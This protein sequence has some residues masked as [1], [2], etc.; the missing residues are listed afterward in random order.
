L[1]SAAALG[2]HFLHLRMLSR[3]AKLYLVATVFQGFGAGIWQV[4]FYLYLNLHEVGFQFDFIGNMFT[5]G[6]VATGLI[7][8]PAG[9]ICERIGAKKALLLGLTA[10][11]ANLVQIVVLQPASLLV[12]S[13]ASGL[14]GTLT[15]VAS[16]PFMV[17]NSG[18]E[19]RTYLFSFQATLGTI[20]AVVG[21]LV[22]GLMPD[23]FNASLG[24]PTGIDGSAVGYRISLAI[25][26]GLSLGVVFPIILVKQ[27][28]A[29][30]GQKMVD[31]LSLR[32]IKSSRTILKFMIPTVLIGFGAGFVVP[33]VNPFFKQKYG[34]TT[35]QVGVI[36]SLGNVTL[37]VAILVTPV[38]SKKLTKARFVVLCQYLSMPFIMSTSLSPNLTWAGASYIARTSLMNM[39]GPIGTTFQ[40]ESVTP[41]ERAT[42]SGLMVMSDGISRAATATISGAMMTGN[43]F[44]TPFVYMTVAYFV[45]SSSY[46]AFFARRVKT[47]AGS[48]GPE[49]KNS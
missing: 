12:A 16:A 20:M 37:A 41:T 30:E 6:A 2:Q 7:A 44:F 25:S 27:R 36:S 43:D 11:L 39:A 23:L 46:F 10:N 34:A 22:G 42:T 38:L 17:E 8:L 19:E 3:N 47:A 5:V 48:S 18:P 9:L 49:Q 28:K 40:M 31:L 35:E 1:Q 33:L 26:V 13:L 29:S 4:L 32:N 24:L 14:I 45:A 15:L 21:S